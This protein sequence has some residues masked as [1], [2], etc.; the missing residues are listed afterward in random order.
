MKKLI[1]AALVLLLAAPVYASS[2]SC[3]VTLVNQGV[4]RDSGNLVLFYDAPGS[5]F[6]DL[7]DAI[8]EE[9]NYQGE[10]VCAPSRQYQPLLNGQPSKVLSAAGQAQDGCPT[11]GQP[12]P[13]PQ[14]TAEF[15]DAVIDLELRNRVIAWKHNAAQDA[16]ND[17]TTIATPDVGGSN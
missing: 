12:T 13:N 9:Y 6:A 5:A 16:A 15:A 1:L 2:R 17:P 11:V 8:L 7:R 14:G 4:C 3:N 10:V